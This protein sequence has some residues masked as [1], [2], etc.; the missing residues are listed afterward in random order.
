MGKKAMRELRY[1]LY[2][3]DGELLEETISRIPVDAL[4][5]SCG[6]E[7]SE[8]SKIRR[9]KNTAHHLLDGYDIRLD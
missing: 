8:E 4:P 9:R 2:D 3:A 6:H 1:R 5:D 7:L